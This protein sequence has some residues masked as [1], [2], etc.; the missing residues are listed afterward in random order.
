MKEF[1]PIDYD[2]GKE[3]IFSVVKYLLGLVMQILHYPFDYNRHK[4]G[5]MT[6][7]Q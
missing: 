7:K 1:H 4:F 3:S 2:E 5:E 6:L